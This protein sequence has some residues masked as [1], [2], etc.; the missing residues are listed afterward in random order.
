[1]A[2]VKPPVDFSLLAEVL[3]S[4]EDPCCVVDHVGRIRHENEAFRDTICRHQQV[5]R[6]RDEIRQLGRRAIIGTSD[7]GNAKGHAGTGRVAEFQAG[8]KCYRAKASL[9]RRSPT[10]SSPLVLVTL[11]AL[12]NMRSAEK[13]GD[14]YRLTPREA[15]VVELLAEGYSNQSV[16]RALGVSTH[17]ARHHTGRVLS[18]L[19]ARGRAEVGAIVRRLHR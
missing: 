15:Q 7:S 19:Q 3:D 1:M 18:K 10:D 13:F 9:M 12:T 8:R 11:E 6:F 2:P 4:I 5:E 14:A 17:T 16:A